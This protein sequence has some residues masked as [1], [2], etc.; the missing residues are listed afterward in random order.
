MA[1]AKETPRQKMIGMMYLVLTALLALN[2]SKEIL[3]GFVKVEKGL[4]QTNQTV[5]GKSRET[6]LE[7]EAK[8]LQDQQKVKPY[9]DAAKDVETKADELYDHITQLKANILAVASGKRE[10]VE[11]GGDISEFIAQD[12]LTRKDTVLS[13]AYFEKKDEYQEITSYLVG[14]EPGDPKT[15]PFTASELKDKLETFRDNLKDVGFT[16]FVG[17]SF[18]VSPGLKASFDQTFQYEKEMEDGKEVLWEAANF[19]DVPLA[20]VIPILSKLQIDIANAKS[21]LMSELIAGIE[22]KSYKFTNLMPLVVPES[23]YILRGDS[24]RADVLLAAFDATNSPNIYVDSR[25]FN[26][27]DSSL[28][29]YNDKDPLRIEGGLGKIRI[30]TKGMSLGERN[31]KG[32]IRFQGPDGNVGDYPFYTPEFTV[33]EPA[34]VVSPTKMNV[35]YRGVPNPVEISVPGVSSDKLDVRITGGHKIKPDG[36]TFIVEPGAGAEASIEVTATLPDG[37]KKSLPGREF[38]VKRIPDPSPRF[39]GKSPSDKTITKVLLENAPSVGAL[40][41]NFDFDVVVKVK[42]FNVTVTKGGTFVEQSSSTNMVTANMKELFRSVGRGSVVYIEDIV[43]SM[44][45]G[46]ERALPTM[47][48][49]VI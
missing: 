21:N 33:A 3:N 16:D 42:R 37:T 4:R 17:N 18:E 28:L 43:V 40:M 15:G 23:N 39:A 49:K 19:F 1:G 11:A 29:A 5:Q 25:E 10:V 35:F 9:Y 13:I 22:G 26:G 20:A 48:L 36:E 38:R 24:F 41:E 12:K 2:I 47:K 6:M 30:A 27:N 45:D 44:P 7:F 31:Y 14:G 34:L 46:T 32:L 8:Y